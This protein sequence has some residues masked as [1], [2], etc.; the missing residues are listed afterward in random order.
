[1]TALLVEKLSICKGELFTAAVCVMKWYTLLY[2]ITFIL[3]N[4]FFT[5]L[6]VLL[7]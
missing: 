5:G 6:L 4:A 7:L 1:M 2:V 3:E